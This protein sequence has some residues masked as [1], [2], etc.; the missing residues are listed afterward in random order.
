MEETIFAIVN[1]ILWVREIRVE[2]YILAGCFVVLAC[3]FEGVVVKPLADYVRR[4]T[5]L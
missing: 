3:V 5:W 2:Y 1:F 4:V